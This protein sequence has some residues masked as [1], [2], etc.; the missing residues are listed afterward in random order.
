MIPIE[1]A[2]DGVLVFLNCGCAGFRARIHPTGAS[3]L[4]LINQTCDEHVG[5]DEPLGGVRLR[6][7][8]K[9]EMVRPFMRAPVTPDSLSA[10]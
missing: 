1:Q 7:V 2:S 9:G 6:S 8:P 10:R 4:V 5:Y 3:A